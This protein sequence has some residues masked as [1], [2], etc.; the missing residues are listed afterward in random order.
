MLQGGFTG[1]RLLRQLRYREITIHS[2]HIS[3][4]ELI[5][6]TKIALKINVEIGTK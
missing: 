5:C 1:T 4:E 6:R 3:K 2:G